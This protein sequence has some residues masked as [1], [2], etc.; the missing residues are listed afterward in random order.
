MRSRKPSTRLGR[1]ET[2]ASVGTRSARD[3]V[4]EEGDYGGSKGEDALLCGVR[5]L[6]GEH[7]GYKAHQSAVA[8]VQANRI[9]NQVELGPV[10]AG[11]SAVVRPKPV[12][13]Q[14]ALTR[15]GDDIAV[16]GERAVTGQ[17]EGDA[18]VF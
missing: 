13:H 17:R 2:S 6:P 16:G 12:Q 14:T 7:R 10:F 1:L 8:A 15:F 3:V 18:D 5:C 9:L 11:H 4:I